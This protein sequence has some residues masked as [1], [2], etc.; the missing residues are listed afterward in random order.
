VSI[1]CRQV[2]EALSASIDT[3]ATALSADVSSHLQSCADCQSAQRDYDDIEKELSAFYAAARPLNLRG[4]GFN[5]LTT[6]PRTANA[7]VL[8]PKWKFAIAA[9]ALVALTVTGLILWTSRQGVKTQAPIA[10]AAPEVEIFEAG[11]AARLVEQDGWH[12]WLRAGSKLK[13]LDKRKLE[14]VSGTVFFSVV[15]G[16]GPFSV[17]TA[18]GMVSVLGTQFVVST[19]ENGARVAVREGTVKL[20]NGAGALAIKAGEAGQLQQNATAPEALTGIVIEEELSWRPWSGLDSVER[21]SRIAWL[22]SVLS[23]EDFNKRLIARE[24]LRDAGSDGLASAE[25]WV[26]TTQQNP[27]VPRL[28]LEALIFLRQAPVGDAEARA[29]ARKVL[30]NNREQDSMREQAAA[31]LGKIGTA[32]DL[33]VFDALQK[34]TA[35]QQRNLSHALSAAAAEIRARAEKN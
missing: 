16:N 17:K 24:V 34:D 12:V 32:E 18:A 35:V 7:T 11:T 2:R 28:R 8:Q 15:P 33:T 29:A 19:T 20:E 14:L 10:T 1:D 4:I 5:S 22:E 13:R 6:E 21:K 27:R 3:P 30:E 26:E 25:Q 23:E 31:T 9:A